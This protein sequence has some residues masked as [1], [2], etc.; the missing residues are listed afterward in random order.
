MLNLQQYDDI[1][2][3]LRS[4]HVQNPDLIAHYEAQRAQHLYS[5]CGSTRANPTTAVGVAL[6]QQTKQNGV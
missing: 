5:V 4:A 1:L 6:Q 3:R 2:T